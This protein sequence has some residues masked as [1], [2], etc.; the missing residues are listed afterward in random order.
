M[1]SFGQIHCGTDEVV[2]EMLE[3]DP[4]YAEAFYQLQS[5]QDYPVQKTSL[6]KGTIKYTIPIVFHV[7]HEYGV[8][9]ISKEQILDQVR[10]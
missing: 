2:R 10:I 8:E 3:K 6:G 5:V 4:S 9:N 1:Y 7:I